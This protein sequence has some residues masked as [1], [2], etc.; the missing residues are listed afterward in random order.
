MKFVL[1]NLFLL[2]CIEAK[3]LSTKSVFSKSSNQNNDKLSLQAGAAVISDDKSTL[4]TSSINLAKCIG[5]AG[6]LSLPAGVALFSD[7][8][9]ALIPSA[10]IATIMGIMSGYTF[11]AIGKAC[12]TYKESSYQELWGKAIGQNTKFFVSGASCAKTIFASLALTIILGDTFKSLALSFNAPNFITNRTNMIIMLSTLILLPLC[13]LKSLA[14]LAPFSI[15]GTFGIVYTAIFMTIRYF[16]GSY[17]EGGEFFNNMADHLKPVFNQNPNGVNKLTMVLLSMLSTAYIA[18]YNAPKFFTELENTNMDRFNFVTRFGFGSSILLFLWIMSIGFLTFGGNS[19]G[20]ILNNYSSSDPLAIAARVSIGLA[21]ITGFPFVFTALR[22]GILDMFKI[23]DKK[24]D[25][26]FMPFTVTLLTLISILA[27][28]LTDVGF[29]VSFAGALFGSSLMFI[30]PATIDAAT[31]TGSRLLL[32]R[33]IQVGGGLLTVLGVSISVLK[34][35]GK[36]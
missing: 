6:V 8:P 31:A 12:D 3:H 9:S 36:I 35:L 4:M 19:Q 29:V 2:A 24:R 20:L 28:N 7:A 32:D 15:L 5:G 25:D 27:I 17:Q 30:I 18:H 10:L 14:S 34:Q 23:K 22:E 13:S 26:A 1:L 11:S 21:L 16:D 33:G